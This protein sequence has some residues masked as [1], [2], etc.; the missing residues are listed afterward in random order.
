[1]DWVRGN[2]VGRGSF[3][4]VNLALP[5]KNSTQFPAATVVKSSQ[6]L[7]SFSIR[8]EK[9][10]LDRL[11]SCSRII[12]CFGDDYTFEDGDEYYNLFLEYAAGGTLADQINFHGGRIPEPLVRRYTRSIVEGLTHIHQNG[13]VHCDIKLPNILVFD[14]GEIKIADFGLA[15]EAGEKQSEGFECR[16]TPLFMSPESVNDGEHESPADIWAL[17]CAMVEMVT[18]KPAWN[19]QKGSSMC[20][21]LFRI[22][23]GEELPEIPEELSQEGKDFLGKC[24][25]KDPSKRW[26]AEML[27]KHPFV[28]DDDDTVSLKHFNESPRTNFDFPDWVSIVA[29]SVPS[30]PE[31]EEAPQWE[32][33]SSRLSIFCSPLDRIRQLVTVQG[34]ENWSEADSWISVR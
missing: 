13:F 25:V 12:R 10:V 28:A 17:G 23:M 1:M 29:A 27:L 26:T 6:V 31:S 9:Q 11:G 24:F 30:S 4:T 19:M 21:L 2:P 33:D 22:G 20:S 5:G 14:D 32:F 16:G 7:N 15:K 8:N 18:G 34:P 3:G